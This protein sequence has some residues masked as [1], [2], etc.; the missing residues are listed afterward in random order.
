MIITGQQKIKLNKWERGLLKNEDLYIFLI[1][2]I[3]E[4]PYHI[5]KNGTDEEAI[6]FCIKNATVK[7]Y[8]HESINFRSR[9]HQSRKK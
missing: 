5:I 1:S 9:L 4:I 7:T 3:N 2:R 6:N 8:P